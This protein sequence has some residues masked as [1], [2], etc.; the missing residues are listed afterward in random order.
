MSDRN[1]WFQKLFKNFKFK[2]IKNAI[3]L[4]LHREMGAGGRTTVRGGRGRAHRS[5][6]RGLPSKAEGNPA[7]QNRPADA[8]EVVVVVAVVATMLRSTRRHQVGPEGY[9]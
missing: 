3:L 8:Q 5:G 6:G 1:S 4:Y 2:F 7:G 9:G